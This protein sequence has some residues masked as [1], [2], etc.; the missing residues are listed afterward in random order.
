MWNERYST[1]EYV[2]GTL[3]NEF[4][5]QT[6]SRIS[7]NNVLCLAEGEGRNAVYLAREGYDVL[8]VD[9]S[10]VGLEKAEILAD[11]S[12]VN[13]DTCVADLSDYDIQPKQWDGIVSIFCH[14]PADVRQRLHKQVVKGLKPGGKLV[15]EAYHPRQAERPTGGPTCP[16]LCVSSMPKSLIAM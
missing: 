11:D 5:I 6:S 4:L 10:P 2:Y 12:Y 7:G 8:A 15:L 16:A 3:P 14:L 13:I 1:Q 9:A